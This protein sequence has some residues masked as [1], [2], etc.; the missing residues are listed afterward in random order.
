LEFYV[1]KSARIVVNKF[2]E[3]LNEVKHTSEKRKGVLKRLS[4]E[5]VEEFRQSGLRT[6]VTPYIHIVG[7]HLFE[8]HE[9]NDLGDYNMQGVE[10][11][12]DLLSRLYFSS[13]N[14]AKNPLLTM[15]PKLYRM[16]EMN[17]QDG[18]ERDAMAEFA[19][20]GVYDFVEEDLSKSESD[21][22][23]HSHLRH[24]QT[25]DKESENESEEESNPSMIETEQEGGETESDKPSL[26]EPEKRFNTTSLPRSENR[27]KSFRRS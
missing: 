4:L 24:S 11:N 3:I 5:F 27:F 18:K 17:F 6:T 16:L 23:N 19:R 1:A 21:S 12:N 8:F 14:P 25:E 13:T 10:K 26:W 20:T 9:L 2:K 15:L 22:E 7:N